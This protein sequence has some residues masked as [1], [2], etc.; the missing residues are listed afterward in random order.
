MVPLF[1]YL[2]STSHI[3]ILKHT[4]LK[5]FSMSYDQEDNILQ[6]S[7]HWYE[8]GKRSEEGPSSSAT[9]DTQVTPAIEDFGELAP[10]VQYLRNGHDSQLNTSSYPA[11]D[12]D[13]PTDDP[14]SSI[15][16]SVSRMQTASPIF[17]GP[18]SWSAQP[19]DGALMSPQAFTG[20]VF[21][22]KE[23]FGSGARYLYPEDSELVGQRQSRSLLNDEEVPVGYARRRGDA[24]LSRRPLEEFEL[25]DI[26][27]K[28]AQGVSTAQIFE[29]YPENTAHDFKNRFRGKWKQW[30]REQDKEL[31]RLHKERGDDWVEISKKLT[32]V[33]RNTDEVRIRLEYLEKR[34]KD[35]EK[36]H[37]APRGHHRYGQE[38][39]DDISRQLAEGMS[40]GELAKQSSFRNIRPSDL[41]R[42]AKLIGANWD[43]DDDEKLQENIMRYQHRDMDIDW[44]SIGK[45]YIPRRDARFVAAHWGHIQ[46][47][48]NHMEESEMSGGAGRYTQ[49]EQFSQ[50]QQYSGFYEQPSS[51]A[52]PANPSQYSTAH[53]SSFQPAAVAQSLEDVNTSSVPRYGSVHTVYLPDNPSEPAHPRPG[54]P[55]SYAGHR[56]TAE[57][58][59]RLDAN[60]PEIRTRLAQDWTWQQVK[61]EYCPGYRYGTMRKFLVSRDCSRWDRQQ[62]QHLLA[63]RRDGLDW[64]QICDQLTDP[65]RTAAE[66]ED[67][68]AWLTKPDDEEDDDNEVEDEEVDE[69]D[70]D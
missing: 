13:Y 26:K 36:Q 58:R 51:Q 11:T 62:D 48:Y 60:L 23:Q 6:T 44:E 31:I 16:P 28:Y 30:T 4:S 25:E 40:Y 61:K 9:Q 50:R 15:D 17:A 59:K 5:P 33:S 46:G 69:D 55:G 64:A 38:E 19:C 52:Y 10:V 29:K 39:N 65:Q 18:S 1:F 35:G 56:A 45:Q 14:F 3:L 12:P 67:R 34:D 70:D 41:K 32:G 53:S 47:R 27:L 20:D 57:Y 68:F 7:L 49:V 42:H 21:V 63:L 66:A 8:V 22:D 43:E 2:K 54:S 37:R 24:R